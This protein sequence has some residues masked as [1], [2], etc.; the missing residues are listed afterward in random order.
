LPEKTEALFFRGPRETP[1]AFGSGAFD[2][3]FRARPARGFHDLCQR[4][5]AGG[6]RRGAA[7]PSAEIFY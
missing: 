7:A 5:G 2:S 4:A 3:I 1:R 6:S